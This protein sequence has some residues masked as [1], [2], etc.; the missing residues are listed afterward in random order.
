M[1]HS[2]PFTKFLKDHA[3]ILRPKNLILGQTLYSNKYKHEEKHK[4]S[5]ECIIQEN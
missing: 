1:V 2:N 3:E 5:K 4:H